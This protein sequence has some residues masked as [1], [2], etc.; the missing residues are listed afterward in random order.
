VIQN[1]RPLP[2]AE[3]PNIRHLANSRQVRRL[4]D[5]RTANSITYQFSTVARIINDEAVLAIGKRIA[6]L[7]ERAGVLHSTK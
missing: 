2:L 6:A 4:M 5:P 7:E 1:V 3:I